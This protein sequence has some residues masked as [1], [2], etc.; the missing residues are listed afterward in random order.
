MGLT[1]TL[2]QKAAKSRLNL[3]EDFSPFAEN[4]SSQ[5]VTVFFGSKTYS[6]TYKITYRKAR[7]LSTNFFQI[8]RKMI[9][10]RCDI[11]PKNYI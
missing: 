8:E 7:K 1:K 5:S 9:V 6:I 10:S 3:S 2:G 4:I 11:L